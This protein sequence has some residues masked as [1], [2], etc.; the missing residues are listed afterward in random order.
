M[1]HICD[2]VNGELVLLRCNNSCSAIVA[3]QDDAL[4]VRPADVTKATEHRL[5]P[6]LAF[7]KGRGITI[8]FHTCSGRLLMETALEVFSLKD[9]LKENGQRQKHDECSE[10]VGDKTLQ[11]ATSTP[12]AVFCIEISQVGTVSVV[13]SLTSFHAAVCIFYRVSILSSS[14][15]QHQDLQTPFK[16]KMILGLQAVCRKRQF[17]N[18]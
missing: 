12:C 13:K 14:T 2:L 9:I 8:I 17:G 4:T 6:R 5:H 3:P 10:L 7:R 11:Q 15:T 18:K 16:F 1:A